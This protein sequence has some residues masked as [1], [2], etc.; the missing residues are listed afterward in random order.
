L[1]LG[2]DT[3][4]LMFMVRTAASNALLP[5][6]QLHPPT[7]ADNHPGRA[8][9]AAAAATVGPSAAW[10]VASVAAAQFADGGLSAVAPT[11]ADIGRYRQ[12]RRRLGTSSAPSGSGWAAT[13]VASVRLPTRPGSGSV[14]ARSGARARAVVGGGGAVRVSWRARV[15]FRITFFSSDGARSVLGV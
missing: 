8:G 14:P 4:L 5:S 9:A 7:A 6:P 3:F 11:P 2:G 15:F 10:H 13:K 12:C 1:C